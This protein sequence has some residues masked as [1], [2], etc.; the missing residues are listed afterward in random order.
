M[1]PGFHLDPKDVEQKIRNSSNHTYRLSPDII[2]KAGTCERNPNDAKA[3]LFVE[4]ST[5]IPVPKVYA[6]FT[7]G[8]ELNSFWRPG[9]SEEHKWLYTTYLVM[10]VIP[11]ATLEDVWNECDPETKTALS[12][13]LKGFLDELRQLPSTYIGSLDNGPVAGTLWPPKYK[14]HGMFYSLVSK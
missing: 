10:S 14:N 11:G 9:D 13:E 3:L 12:K 8:P 5:S 2:V 4:K 7:A 6:L 1:R